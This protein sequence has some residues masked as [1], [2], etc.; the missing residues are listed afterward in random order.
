ML[1]FI[2]RGQ[3]EVIQ[4]ST[5]MKR[6]CVLAKLFNITRVVEC[7]QAAFRGSRLN[8][9]STKPFVI[10]PVNQNQ[11]KLPELS[12]P[13]LSFWSSPRSTASTVN[14]SIIP[15]SNLF[16]WDFEALR[17]TIPVCLNSVNK[18]LCVIQSPDTDA[19]DWCMFTCVVV[20]PV[21]NRKDVGVCSSVLFFSRLDPQGVCCWHGCKWQYRNDQKLYFPRQ[22][23]MTLIS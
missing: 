23:Y 10:P 13:I 12:W 2:T 9:V 20:L 7:S 18:G 3:A 22:E 16:L 8:P 15:F 6:S 14:S 19:C 5:Q 11:I 17:L 21:Q 1:L 4:S